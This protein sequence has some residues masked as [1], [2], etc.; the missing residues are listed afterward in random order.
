[1]ILCLVLIL[2]SCET[3]KLSPE[4]IVPLLKISKPDRP[5]LE[6]ISRD[7][8]EAIKAFT[9]NL[10]RMDAYISQL[11]TFIRIQEDYHAA[12]FEIIHRNDN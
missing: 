5:I 1:M 4:F 11:E 12:I 7:T 9:V 2:T 6:S 10:S 3:S 8:T